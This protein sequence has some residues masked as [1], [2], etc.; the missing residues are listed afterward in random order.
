MEQMTQQQKKKDD[1]AA[2]K[3]DMPPAGAQSG[4]G[5]T[6]GFGKDLS[7]AAS[8]FD[9]AATADVGAKEPQTHKP[10][11]LG[12]A[13]GSLRGGLKK[14]GSFGPGR[15]GGVMWNQEVVPDEPEKADSTLS[16]E[17]G[18]PAASDG[19]KGAASFSARRQSGKH[20]V[21]AFGALA[22]V[23]VGS[24]ARRVG[25][26]GSRRLGSVALGPPT[27]GGRLGAVRTKLAAANW[28]LREVCV[29]RRRLPPEGALAAWLFAPTACT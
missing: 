17:L 4:P 12:K 21:A 1:E 11:V 27:F 7:L 18:G 16:E 20:G 14:H 22:L 2:A 23:P 3:H 5:A 26:S 13:V 29:G 19:G 15:G 9:S 25:A 24:S 8:E 6:A 28:A 10:V